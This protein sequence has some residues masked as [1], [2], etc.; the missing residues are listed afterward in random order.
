MDIRP[1][2]FD[3]THRRGREGEHRL[4]ADAA[5]WQPYGVG[6]E[7]EPAGPVVEEEPAE[8]APEEKP[9]EPVVEVEAT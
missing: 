3:E 2:G 6:D 7:G 1:Q 9:V 5:K 4:S 8:P